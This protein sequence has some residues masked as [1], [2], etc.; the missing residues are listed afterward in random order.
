MGGSAELGLRKRA[1]ATVLV[2]YDACAGWRN[3]WCRSEVG[4]EGR[5]GC[6]LIGRLRGNGAHV[7]AV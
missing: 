7:S 3:V 2:I 4:I 1:I 5:A 6:L